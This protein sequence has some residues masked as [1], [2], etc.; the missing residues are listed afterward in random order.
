M[1]A[2]D[3]TGVVASADGGGQ[4]KREVAVVVGRAGCLLSCRGLQQ[5]QGLLEMVSVV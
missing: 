3:V 5:D 1:V 2:V 4:G